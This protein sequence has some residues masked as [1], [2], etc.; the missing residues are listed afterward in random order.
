MSRAHKRY[1]LAVIS[2]S[3]RAALLFGKAPATVGHPEATVAAAL[4]H[5]YVAQLAF[6]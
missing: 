6:Q 3:L 2:E 4:A 1:V 5:G